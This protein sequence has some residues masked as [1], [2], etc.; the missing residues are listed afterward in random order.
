M[1]ESLYSVHPPGATN[2]SAAAILDGAEFFGW[3]CALFFC[4]YF[5]LSD[6]ILPSDNVTIRLQMEKC[7]HFCSPHNCIVRARKGFPLSPHQKG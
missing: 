1:P 3:T 2:T 5:S 7:M 4:S 6:R